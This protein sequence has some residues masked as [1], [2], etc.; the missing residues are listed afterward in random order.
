MSKSKFWCSTV[1]AML[2]IGSL[3]TVPALTQSGTTAGNGMIQGTVKAADGS[4][5]EGVIVSARASHE[6][7]TTS[8]YSDRQGNYSFPSRPAGQY[9]MW[10]QA[11][12]FDAAKTEFALTAGGRVDRNLTLRPLANARVIANQLD[13]PEWFAALPETNN[14]DRRMK[15]LLRNNCTACHGPAYVLAPRF[16]ARGWRNIIDVMARGVPPTRPTGEGNATWQAYK[17]ELAEYLGRVTKD[18][19]PKPGPQTAGAATRAVITEYDIPRQGRPIS[20]HTGTFWTEGQSTRFESKGARDIWIDSKGYLWVSDDRSIGRTTGR[21]DPRT[22]KWTDYAMPD[23]KGV[24]TSSHGIWGDQNDNV[25]QGGQPDGAI[26]MFDTKTEEFVHFA[27]PESIPR[28]SGHI[29][30]DSQNNAWTPAEGGALRLNGKTGEYT[31]YPVPYP[32]SVPESNRD[33]YGLAVDSQD[34]VWIARPG[35]EAVAYIEAKTGKVGHVTFEPMVF[36][37]LTEKDRTVE[38]GM[39]M[40]PPNGKGPRRLGAG[41][42]YGGNYVWVALNKS[43]ALA[44]IDIRTKQVVKEYPLPQGSA[45]YF[46]T[47][48]KN[49]NVWVPP[50][51]ADRIFK[52]DPRTEQVTEFQ[53]PTRGTDLRHL[54]VDNTT[55]PPTI[56]VTY[57]RSNKI[58]RLQE[59]PAGAQQAAR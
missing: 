8:V 59:R 16:D 17:D 7:W 38:V 35:M 10:A 9:S 36:P 46:A 43:D 37:G 13:G 32:D 22:G 21:L 20:V 49:G 4:P 54:T 52:F 55:N 30:V 45:P 23:A 58:A 2:I 51:N 40:G 26:L 15:H 34:N 18:L 14:Q 24:A 56:W 1:A 11:K 42:R 27:R 47:V 57:N 53:L 28:G 29:D 44:K 19:Q 25:Y 41:G 6:T 39:N 31:F 48:D 5:I 33:S 50:Q 3:W 12:G